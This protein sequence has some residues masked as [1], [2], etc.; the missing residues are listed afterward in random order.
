MHGR[1]STQTTAAAASAGGSKRAGPLCRARGVARWVRN[2]RRARQES[3]A[4]FCGVQAAGWLFAAVAC[5]AG[6]H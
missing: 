2:R 5:V 3:G 6:A 1:G 4:S